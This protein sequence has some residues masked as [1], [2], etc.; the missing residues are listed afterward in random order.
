[1]NDSDGNLDKLENRRK[2]AVFDAALDAFGRKG[3]RHA[4]TDEIAHDAGMSKGLLFYYFGTKQALYLKTA[5]WLTARVESIVLDE[6][7]WRI[8]DFFELMLYLT[9]ACRTVVEKF[10]AAVNFSLGLFYPEHRDAS[11]GLADWFS[12]Q[13]DAMLDRYLVNVRLDKF[14]DDVDPRHVMDMLVWLA[15]GWL[16]QRRSRGQRIDLAAMAQEM[17]AWCEMLRTWSYKEE[18]L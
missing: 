17:E 7:F 15:D 13:T 2:E 14:R 12:R 3:Y 6:D 11:R 4:R 5:E 18:Y 8:D 1:M 10:P 9:R 16:H